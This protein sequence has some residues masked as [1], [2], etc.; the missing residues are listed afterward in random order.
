M[1]KLTERLR[2]YSQRRKK[3]RGLD[4]EHIHSFDMS[5]DG[6]FE[7][8]LSDID[9]A[10]ARIEHLERVLVQARYA[11]KYHMDQTRPI[12]NTQNAIAAIDEALKENE[13][14]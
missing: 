4:I 8:L 7:L 14:G 6:G 1:S 13:H 11:M 12:F 10:V 2:A 5:P 9:G 3:A